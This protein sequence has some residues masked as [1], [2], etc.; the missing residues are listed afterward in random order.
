MSVLLFILWLILNANITLEIV[1]LGVVLVVMVLA[2]MTRLTDYSFRQELKLW[3]KVPLAIAY[4]G[5]LVW[6]ILKANKTVARIIL[7]RRVKVEQTVVYVDID[8]KTDFCKM[9]MA[10]SITLTPGTMTAS[11]DG[12]TFTVHC[13]S[14]EMLDG[15]ES[16]TFVR[17]LQ[18]LEA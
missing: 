3:R 7:D 13:L 11:V 10:N 9:L 16:S 14:R 2:A 1:I 4:V 6:E 18:R 8:L 17:L 5:V 15:I 12:N